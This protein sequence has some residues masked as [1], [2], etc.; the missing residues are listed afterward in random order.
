MDEIKNLRIQ[1]FH[2]NPDMTS[3]VNSIYYDS[4]ECEDDWIEII[5]D[6]ISKESYVVIIVIDGV[7]V[8]VFAEKNDA[9]HINESINSLIKELL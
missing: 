2:F 8:K 3:E 7:T 4:N 9:N 5:P 1:G 6:S